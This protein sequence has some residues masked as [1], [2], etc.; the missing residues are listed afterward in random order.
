[1]FVN[2]S[3]A[4]RKVATRGKTSR[5]SQEAAPPPEVRVRYL[6]PDGVPG[7]AVFRSDFRIGRDPGC[8]LVIAHEDVSREH[9]AVYWQF[10]RWMVCDLGSSNGTYLNGQPFT[11]ALLAG[12]LTLELAS[13][14][15]TITLEARDR[16]EQARRDEELLQKHLDPN[17]R[18]PVGEQ[19]M[20]LRRAVQM[21]ARK[22]SRSYRVVAVVALVLLVGAGVFSAYQFKE[23]ENTRAIGIEIFY[24]I[25]AMDLQIAQMERELVDMAKTLKRESF[26]LEKQRDAIAERNRRLAELEAKYRA[27]VEKSQPL[28][29]TPLGKVLVNDVDVLIHRVARLFGECELIVPEDFSAEVKRYIAKWQSTKRLPRAI[30]RLND[31][32]MGPDIA[33]AFINNGLPPHFL[34]LALQESNFRT[35]AVG[36]ITRYGHAKGMWQFIPSTGARYGLHPGPLKDEG[37]FDPYDDRHDFEKSTVA[38]AK[39]IGDIY[40]TDAQASGLLV[41]ASYNWG[42]G[43]IIKRIRKLPENPKDRNFWQLLAKYKIPDE[44]YNYVLHIFSAAVIGENPELFGFEFQN[45][46]A[47]YEKPESQG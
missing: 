7:T 20:I 46:L 27:L 19:T 14:G 40:R 34:Y 15:P 12:P 21:K 31:N 25:K 1:M 38:A 11:E 26:E 9:I 39:Y 47:A 23:V 28:A 45:P 41:M 3:R 13:H 29:S 36:P 4:T 10:G 24:S 37:V 43:N 44:T 8:D 6:G 18:G 5:A 17:Y 2:G 33:Q 32:A 35:Q 22:Q 16:V 30:K 42:E